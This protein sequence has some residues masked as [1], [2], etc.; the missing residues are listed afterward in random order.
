MSTRI[1]VPKDLHDTLGKLLIERALGTSDIAVARQRKHAVLAEIFESFERARRSGITS[2]DIEHEA[3][4][5]LQERFKTLHSRS[6]DICAPDEDAMTVG[7][8]AVVAQHE[9][10]A[11]SQRTKA[12]L[13]AAKARGQ[14]L[15]GARRGAARIEDFQQ[16]GAQ[17]A[18]EK[19]IALAELRR[20]VQ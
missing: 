13:A 3:Q 8:M 6:G 7:I 2:G 16:Q 11:I 4:L 5:F 20:E 18:R 14:R 1:P 10:E 12:A 19:A 17:A 15:G 9:R